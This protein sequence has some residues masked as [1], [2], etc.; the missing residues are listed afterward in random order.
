M[1]ATSLVCYI[2]RLGL[3]ERLDLSPLG[4]LVAVWG[5]LG[6]RLREAGD[7][8]PVDAVRP[9][10]DW[11]TRAA[12]LYLC[13]TLVPTIAIVPAGLVSGALAWRLAAGSVGPVAMLVLV[14]AYGWAAPALEVRRRQVVGGAERG[15]LRAGHAAVCAVRRARRDLGALADPVP[16]AL[17][18][19]ALWELAGVLVAGER[20]R[21]ARREVRAALDL[22]AADEPLAGE[23][24]SREAELTRV[25][26][27]LGTEAARRLASLRDLAA[28]C[29]RLTAEC[30]ATRR[31][32]RAANAAD[33]VLA[34]LP[35]A[36]RPLDPVAGAAEVMS[37]TLEAYRQMR[38]T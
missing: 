16:P 8:R 29:G 14:L 6:Q 17:L 27:A 32:G 4:V 23:L 33:A 36:R 35:S 19:R 26:H 7:D 1:G 10:G 12:W 13:A 9:A 18:D 21:L 5:R 11:R 3:V 31:A 38:S 24:R 25:R 34:S 28:T 15:L 20:A 2:D 22:L 30:E 37:A